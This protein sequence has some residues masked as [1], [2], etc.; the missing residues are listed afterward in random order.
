MQFRHRWFAGALLAGAALVVVTGVGTESLLAAEAPAVTPKPALGTKPPEGAIALIPQAPGK[1][2][3]LD[4]WNKA[5]KAS[6][7]GYVTAGGGDIVTRRA[8]GSMRLHVEFWIPP[9]PEGKRASHGGNSGVYIMDRY[10]VQ[11]LDS[12]GQKPQAGGCGGIY[13]RIPPK[14]NAALP[15]GRWQSYDIAFHAPRFD[16]AGKKVRPVHITVV[17]N[18][19]TVHDDQEVPGP[20]GQA[21]GKKEVAK[22]PLRL[23]DHGCPVRFRNVWLVPLEE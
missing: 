6:P 10:E 14:V 11:I 2:P 13:R 9:G 3:A 23:Q 19:I 7:E 16:A 8:F 20:T 21:S 12:H 18:G 22:A 5:W 4:H 15:A 1:E 17:H